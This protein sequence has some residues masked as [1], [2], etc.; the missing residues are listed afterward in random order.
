MSDLFA[1]PSL[2]DS[3]AAER[4]QRLARKD[5]PPTSKAAAAIA[6]RFKQSHADAI[7]GVL[8]RG[9]IPPEIAKF[10]GLTVV[11]IDRRR[12]ELLELGEIR[13]TG[14]ERDGYQEWE[15]VLPS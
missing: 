1:D 11:Q 4:A 10:T 12:K 13:L 14:R 7:I 15:R 6:K 2:E 5:D 8:W 3:I 9:M